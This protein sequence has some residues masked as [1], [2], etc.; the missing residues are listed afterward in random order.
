MLGNLLWSWSKGR[1]RQGRRL[2]NDYH[3]NQIIFVLGVMTIKMMM[4]I[5]SIMTISRQSYY[6][7][8]MVKNLHLWKTREVCIWSLSR[9]VVSWKIPSYISTWKSLS[10]T[11]QKLVNISLTQHDKSLSYHHFNR[12]KTND[13]D[14]EILTGSAGHRKCKVLLKLGMIITKLKLVVVFSCFLLLL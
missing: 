9:A 14:K 3:D 4:T 1:V 5:K 13:V 8:E 12:P 11:D 10:S 2:I 6:N 7:T